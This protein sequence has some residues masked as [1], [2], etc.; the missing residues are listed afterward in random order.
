[1]ENFFQKITRASKE[2]RLSEKE[3]NNA[4][5]ALLEFME[6]RPVRKAED[7]R[8]IQGWPDI[9]TKFYSFMLRP[10]PI[11][12]LAL[13]LFL[14]G[15]SGVAAGALPGDTL[16]PVKIASESVVTAFAFSPEKKAERNI[17]LA[18][19]R[20]QEAET[21]LARG[22]L[23]PPTAMAVKNAVADT[24]AAAAKNIALLKE[25]NKLDKALS[26]SSSFE[27][28][29]GAHETV[30]GRVAETVPPT[31]AAS[32]SVA[33]PIVTLVKEQKD[34]AVLFRSELEGVIASQPEPTLTKLAE[35]LSASRE[36]QSETKVEQVEEQINFFPDRLE[37]PRVR[38][39][40]MTPSAGAIGTKVTLS[41]YAFK[42]YSLNKPFGET[43]INFG[44]GYVK[45]TGN[46]GTLTFIVPE[47][48]VPKCALETD[49][50]KPRCMVPVRKTAPGVYMVNVVTPWGESNAMM[51]KVITPIT[52]TPIINSL[53]PTSGSVGAVVTIIGSGF[54]P[55]GNKLKFGELGSEDNPSYILNSSDGKTL[56]FTVPASNY[57]ACWNS[58]PACGAPARLTQPGIYQVSVINANGTSNTVPFKVVKTRGIPDPNPIVPL[59]ENPTFF[60]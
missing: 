1:M 41:G 57:L 52:Q 47:S 19:R 33:A 49:K 10:I 34:A 12:I 25:Q 59:L 7:I 42:Q 56:V 9:I 29:L 21:L 27:I 45:A 28:A 44:D 58:T 20:L 5:S 38:I 35:D 39:E 4:R 6:S 40:E 51:F 11:A 24:S 43:Y 53:Q 55:T 15:I 37:I 60:E 13:A 3:K 31:E 46:A 17:A 32:E 8:H 50:N 18:E 14:G 54:T 26:L 48:I 22:E 23:T 2:E 16:Y 30:L 36:A